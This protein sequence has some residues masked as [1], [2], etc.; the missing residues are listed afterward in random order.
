MN[1]KQTSLPTAQ[2]LQPEEVHLR[3][4]LNVIRRRRKVFL[5][6]FAAVFCGIVLYTFVMQP[7]YE[8]SATLHV[9]DEK[10]KA[11]MLG[12][13]ALSEVNPVDSEIEIIKARTNAEQVVK[14]LHLDWRLRNRASGLSFRLLDFTSTA[15]DPVYK[16]ELTGG[17]GYKV[18]DED[19]QLVGIGK[20]SVPMRGKGLNL[21]LDNL[22]GKAGDTCGLVLSPFPRMGTPLLP[23]PTS[24]PSSSQTL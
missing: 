11:G 16:I 14:S 3:D 1:Q 18:W 6:A 24:W 21:L 8:A 12:E 23:I 20:S 13:L 4:Y 17:D 15:E 10:T 7:V 9:K 2:H 22:T 19:G 5:S